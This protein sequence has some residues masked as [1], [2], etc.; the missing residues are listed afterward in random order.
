MNNNVLR[1]LCVLFA[2]TLC[3]P[4]LALAQRIVTVP[5]SQGCPSGYSQISRD[6]SKE[7]AQSRVPKELSDR[8][9]RCSDS[10]RV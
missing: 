2:G 5:E 1:T 8:Y 7:A 6:C 9:R 4:A 10:S 3:F